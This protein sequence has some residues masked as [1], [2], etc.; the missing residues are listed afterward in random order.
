LPLALDDESLNAIKTAATPLR[1]HQRDLYLKIV[2]RLLEQT[3]TV[4]AGAVARVARSVQRKILNG[5]IKVVRK[6]A[7]G[8]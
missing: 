4:G 1:P 7:A 5:E 6:R 8:A 2:T 3:E